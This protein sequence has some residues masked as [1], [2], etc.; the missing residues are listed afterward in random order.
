VGSAALRENATLAAIS[1]PASTMGLLLPLYLAHLGYPVAVIGGLLAFSSIATLLSRFVVPKLYRPERSRLL[2]FLTLGGG[3]LS[4]GIL[5]LLP[6]LASFTALLTVNRVLYGIATTVFLARYLDLVGMGEG[7]DRRRAMGLYGGT[8]A[9]GYTTSNAIIGLVADFIGYQAAFLY[10][11]VFSA[12]AMVLLALS[13][14]LTPKPAPTAAAAG[15]QRPRGIRG[16]LRAMADP[17]LWSVMNVGTWNNLFHNVLVSFFPVF[18]TQ[19]GMGPAQIGL[20]RSVYSALNAVSRPIAGVVM[21]RMSLRQVTYAGLLIQA[22][23]IFALPFMDA[24]PLVLTLF[25]IVA[26]GRSVVVVSNSVQLVEEV[27]E[28]RVSRGLATSAYSMTHDVSSI[29]SP[30]LAGTIASI[31]GVSGMFSVMAV[32]AIVG[33]LAGDAAIMRWRSRLRT[34]PVGDPG[35]PSSSPLLTAAGKP[36]TV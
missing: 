27:D 35:S 5:P 12:I 20:I 16:R 21:G 24:F 29:A 15:E 33:F 23:L 2:L 17:G 8:Q 18:A 1:G 28:T 14:E 6:D 25:F 32:V 19:I 36:D 13:P 34:A 3:G 10:G 4:Y 22:V 31:V 11:T 9:A 26:L 7:A 30:V